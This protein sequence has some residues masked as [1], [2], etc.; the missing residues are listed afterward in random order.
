M[1]DYHITGMEE[2]MM[3]SFLTKARRGEPVFLADVV[4]AFSGE[5]T[6]VCCELEPVIG[7]KRYW[8]IRLPEAQ[9]TEE[10][11]FVKEYFYARLYNLISTF[12][13]TRM[14]LTIAPGDETA[15]ALCET[16]DETFQL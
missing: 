4:K 14:V 1:A 13:G 10:L 5:R 3:Q 16:L 11:A 7:N 6:R 15:K 12:G 8:E 2:R 9:N